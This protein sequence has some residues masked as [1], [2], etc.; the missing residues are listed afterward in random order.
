MRLASLALLSLLVPT[1]AWS[2][3]LPQSLRQVGSKGN[4]SSATI[5]VFLSP[6]C[7]CSQSHLA[8]LTELYDRYQ[9]E[10]VR[11]IGIDSSTPAEKAAEGRDYFSSVRLPF[12]VLGDAD[13]H[14]AN[15]FSAVATPHAFFFDSNGKLLYRGGVSDRS[16]YPKSKDHYLE[17]N[18]RAWSQGLAL[19]WTVTR[20]LGCP[21]PH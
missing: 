18:L 20:A 10:G 14:Y 8:A 7:P 4:S 11:W 2:L 19:P 3:D 6:T 21:I 12:P 5:V 9:G 17:A 1:L 16:N 15:L 13:L